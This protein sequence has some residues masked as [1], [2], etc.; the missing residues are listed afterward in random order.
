MPVDRNGSFV[1]ARDQF[2]SNDLLNAFL[3][4][5]ADPEHTTQV[6]TE[7]ALTRKD[8]ATPTF[9]AALFHRG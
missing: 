1:I 5:S 7:W 2:S 6:L 8:P 4:K 9:Q 3:N